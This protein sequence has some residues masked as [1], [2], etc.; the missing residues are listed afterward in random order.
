MTR[1]RIQRGSRGT[2]ITVA[3]IVVAVGMV[4]STVII[5][6]DYM[7]KPEPP[8][9]AEG[10][11]F[12]EQLRVEQKRLKEE[13]GQLEQYLEEYDSSPAVLE[14]LAQVYSALAEYARWLGIEE[15]PGYLEKAADI[16]QS[17]VVAEPGEVR[18][19]FML[20]S[21]YT[22]LELEEKAGEQAG[23]VRELLEKKQAQDTLVNLD[24]FYYAVLLDEC[25]GN[26]R[27]ALN[28][29]AVILDTEPEESTL[30][31]Q[32]ESYREQLESRDPGAPVRE[33]STPGN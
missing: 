30:Y 11:N 3:A 7:R 29:L 12:L 31:I 28:Q 33:G 15:R 32:A 14:H 6:I 4:L 19:Q 23:V 1:K 22:G 21:T 2:L 18:Y 26:R 25:D 27:E 17:L 24:R 10:E 13:A 8:A 16:Y 20:Y 5:Y 9:S